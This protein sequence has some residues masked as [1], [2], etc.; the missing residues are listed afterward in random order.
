[1]KKQDAV[2]FFAEPLVAGVCGILAAQ[3]DGNC[4]ISLFYSPD[5]IR[6]QIDE[7]NISAQDKNQ[8]LALANGSYASEP[9]PLVTITGLAAQSLC[10]TLLVYANYL[11]KEWE[12][13]S[14]VMH[15]I[16]D[17]FHDGT[18]MRIVSHLFLTTP[19]PDA[20][21]AL[22]LVDG[23]EFVLHI[24]YD[25]ASYDALS[26]RY[27]GRISEDQAKRF[28]ATRKRTALPA[29]SERTPIEVRDPGIKTLILAQIFQKGDFW[30]G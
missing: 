9:K 12:F 22:T 3:K 8:L 7:L 23:K 1:M 15:R 28:S 17:R 25:C 2:W 29:R 14:S 21:V 24:I 10:N 16:F 26:T 5:Q 13:N 30:V 20:D 4:F 11:G 6:G 27:R 19:H 18:G